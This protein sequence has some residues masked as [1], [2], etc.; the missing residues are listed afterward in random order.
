[1]LLDDGDGESDGDAI[2]RLLKSALT[3]VAAVVMALI[4]F[5]GISLLPSFLQ[6]QDAGS[7]GIGVAFM[8]FGPV[9]WIVTMLAFAGG[10]WW[11]FRRGRR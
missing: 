11:Q 10:F 9:F 5:V 6:L 3:G 8:T 4:L 2:A 7:G 1:V